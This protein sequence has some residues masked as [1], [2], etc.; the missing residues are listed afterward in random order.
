MLPPICIP[1]AQCTGINELIGSIQ[2]KQGIRGNSK[3]S[4]IFV[5]LKNAICY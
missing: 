3:I 2:I 1:D 4:E 5:D